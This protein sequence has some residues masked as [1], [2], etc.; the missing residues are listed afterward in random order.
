MVAS[1]MKVLWG[2]LIIPFLVLGASLILGTFGGV[3]Q[4]VGY[5]AVS[6]GG[7]D[8]HTGR[9][10]W[11][12]LPDKKGD[13]NVPTPVNVDGR[14][15]VATENNGARLYGFDGTG[16]IVPTPLAENPRFAPDT[17]T[18]VAIDGLVFGCWRG[19]FCLDVNDLQTRYVV[20]E[21]DA[22]RNYAAFLAGNGHVLAVTVGGALVLLQASPEGFT[23]VA[24]LQVF[25]DTEVWSHP[26]L[27]GNRL[28]LRSMKE[29]C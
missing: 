9:R 12:L 19:L 8:P 3:R 17:S 21:D 11:K 25:E 14:L 13:Y 28:Y 24:R 23:P 6:L 2:V 15:L 26:A 1:W 29:V 18:P 10:L 22:F 16:R 5:D 4:I 7:W 27:V 20:D